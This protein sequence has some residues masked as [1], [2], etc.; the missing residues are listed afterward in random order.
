ME[1]LSAENAFFLVHYVWCKCSIIIKQFSVITASYNG[2][3]LDKF[4]KQDSTKA[5]KKGILLNAQF[6]HF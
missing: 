2:A 1:Y 5:P 3:L 4:R 6:A